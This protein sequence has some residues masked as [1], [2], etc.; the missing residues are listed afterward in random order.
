MEFKNNVNGPHT[1]AQAKCGRA[2]DTKDHARMHAVEV[3]KEMQWV[4]KS[5]A[6]CLVSLCLRRRKEISIR[7]AIAGM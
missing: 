5:A 7:E 6:S 3:A 1:V 4:S 2:Q